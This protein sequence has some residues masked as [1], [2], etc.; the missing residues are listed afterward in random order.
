MATRHLRSPQRGQR[1]RIVH[2]RLVCGRRPRLKEAKIHHWICHAKRLACRLENV[3]GKHTGS[4][5]GNICECIQGCH[6]GSILRSVN[7]TCASKCLISKEKQASA[8]ARTSTLA[9]MPCRTRIGGRAPRRVRIVVTCW[10]SNF[11]DKMGNG[12]R[13]YVSSVQGADAPEQARARQ[14]L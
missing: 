7:A 6:F 2:G 11:L 4:I 3:C 10:Q 9:H 1:Q 8:K 13:S 5:R 14:V 12:A